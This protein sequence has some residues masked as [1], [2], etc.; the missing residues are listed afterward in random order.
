MSRL[1]VLGGAPPAPRRERSTPSLDTWRQSLPRVA[2]ADR[3][4]SPA[5]APAPRHVSLW[6]LLVWAYRLQKVRR[7][8]R[9]PF[10]WIEF[11]IAAGNMLGDMT[12]RATV[13]RDAAIV[14]LAMTELA[15][16]DRQLAELLMDCA[17]DAQIPERS[18][19]EPVPMPT[20]PANFRECD[21][22][23]GMWQGKL[24][25][26]VVLTTEIA[27]EIEEEWK[28]RGRRMERVGETITRTPVQYCPIDWRPDPH[29]V[30]MCNHIADEFD[31]GM[32]ALRRKLKDAALTAHA[33]DRI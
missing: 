13:H 18:D 26:A 11:E 32:A 16:E 15:R 28:R 12:E 24:V 14:H 1:V 7:Y 31:R 17:E 6:E 2:D 21:C 22:C 19:A 3:P 27:V 4:A 8:L 29:F 9:R 20:E 23:R 5:S 33:I 25:Y 10:D 30:A